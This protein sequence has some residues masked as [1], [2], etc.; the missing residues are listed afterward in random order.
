M[1]S[2]IANT[3]FSVGSLIFPPVIQ[4]LEDEYGIRGALLISGAAML[5]SVAGAFFQRTP[6]PQ[7]QMGEVA[8]DISCAAAKKGVSVNDSDDISAVIG[9]SQEF[10]E[11]QCSNCSHH[12]DVP[13]IHDY[14]GNLEQWFMKVEPL[15]ED[16][17]RAGGRHISS[18]KGDAANGDADPCRS[19]G[20]SF[21][22]EQPESSTAPAQNSLVQKTFMNRD[23]TKPC[24]GFF[25]SFLF[26]PKFYL[27]LFSFSTVYFNM[28]TYMTV[29]VDFGV[30]LGIPAWNAVYLILIY[31]VADMLA[32]VGSGWITDRNY[33]QESTIMGL[34]FALWGAALYLM[35][36]YSS[37]SYQVTLSIV[38]GW[39]NGSTLILVPVLFMKLVGIEKL[40]VCFGIGTSFVGLVGLARPLLIGWCTGSTL[41]L[42]P[43]LLMELVS[44]EK[45]GVCFGISTSFVG[46]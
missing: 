1:A 39:C 4:A 3:G 17:H 14:D 38:S 31:S 7:T 33:L 30:D 22:Q 9:Q 35:P 46:L 2:G 27:L 10:E 13:R 29:A 45:F 6:V 44:I 21:L 42:I 25:R 12:N 28:V 34:H 43:V 23:T 32:R 20:N 40:S 26:L 15:T 16:E 18:V 41:I 37:Y 19:R 11:T 8:Q 36:M 24:E 5:N